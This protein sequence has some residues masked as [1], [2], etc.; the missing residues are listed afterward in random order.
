[1]ATLHHMSAE[2]V[3]LMWEWETKRYVTPASR[4]NPD[5]ILLRDIYH[6]FVEDRMVTPL[7]H[8]WDN[9]SDDKT[10]YAEPDE[11]KTVDDWTEE[12]KN[13][14]KSAEG[15]KKVCEANKDCYQWNFGGGQCAI[16]WTFRMGNPMGRDE[17]GRERKVS[18]WMLD[19]IQSFIKSQDCSKKVDWKIE[20]GLP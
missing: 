6:A 14:H 16:S 19:R 13:A 15:C 7:R 2:E 20:K 9:L 17:H 5:P 10:Y 18:G 1:M 3:S 4:T 12:E 11:G 8:D